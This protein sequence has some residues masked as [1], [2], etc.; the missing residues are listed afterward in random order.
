MLKKIVFSYI[1]NAICFI[2]LAFMFPVNS[3]ADCEVGDTNLAYGTPSEPIDASEDYSTYLIENG[4]VVYTSATQVKPAT[5]MLEEYIDGQNWSV[6]F[7]TGVVSGYAACG[8]NSY[9]ATT[10]YTSPWSSAFSG[11]LC[12][13]DK[14]SWYFTKKVGTSSGWNAQ[15]TECHQI[16]PKTCAEY[17]IN[18]ANFRARLLG[19]VEN[20]PIVQ[21]TNK[22]YCPAG[23]YLPANSTS[24]TECANCDSGFYCLGGTYDVGNSYPSGRNVCPSN[25][26]SQEGQSHCTCNSGY[27][28]DGD[29]YGDVNVA[30]G[31]SCQKI[32]IDLMSVDTNVYWYNTAPESLASLVERGVVTYRRQDGTEISRSNNKIQSF[33]EFAKDLTWGATFYDGQN[34]E[35]YTVTGYAFCSTKSNDTTTPMGT[36]RVYGSLDDQAYVGCWC[37]IGENNNDGNYW[38]RLNVVSANSDDWYV[39]TD[40]CRENC[41]ALCAEAV[42]TNSEFREDIYIDSTVPE[43]TECETGFAWSDTSYMCKRICPENSHAN[44]DNDCVCNDGYSTDGTENSS[45]YNNNSA[46]Q[47][48]LHCKTDEFVLMGMCQHCPEN[49]HSDGGNIY[50]CQCDTDYT[51]TGFVDGNT[52]TN[53]F[54]CMNTVFNITYDYTN[55]GAGCENET[56]IAGEYKELNCVPELYGHTF[57]GWYDINHNKITHISEDTRKDIVV[58]AYWEKICSENEIW[59]G[60]TCVCKSGF[61]AIDIPWT[62]NYKIDADDYEPLQSAHPETYEILRDAMRWRAIY[63]NVSENREMAGIV[64]SGDAYCS[65]EASRNLTGT[66]AASGSD[67]RDSLSDEGQYCWC[68]MTAP[69]ISRWVYIADISTGGL[70]GCKKRCPGYCGSYISGVT[71]KQSVVR[72]AIYDNILSDETKV[73]VAEDYNDTPTQPD[74]TCETAKYLR[75][76]ENESD[77]MCLSENQATHHALAVGIGNET[78]YV[79]M[80]QQNLTINSESSKKMRVLY[81]NNTYNVYDNSA[82]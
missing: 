10:T 58:Y 56:Y 46:C 39:D 2:V 80:G 81:N 69:A 53:G 22:K 19:S 75:I 5:G 73:C 61:E 23:T 40:Y 35:L 76:G 70:E 51:I 24:N 72:K 11:C 6:E 37:K 15:I 29:F 64:L 57:M 55:G 63:E 41:P 32:E 62:N 31:E 7:E 54:A 49:S 47:E 42:A 16:C 1:Q 18:D 28:K 3:F 14:E 74:D 66:T 45:V 8:G 67:V 30:Y 71:V 68:R 43:Q 65:S 4:I 36:K 79:N 9:K 52:T 59:N 82:E 27:S 20:C 17:M 34:N 60:N 48:I 77:K 33:T 38:T 13:L 44:A 25:S 12:S 78:Y 26:S 21:N 50:D